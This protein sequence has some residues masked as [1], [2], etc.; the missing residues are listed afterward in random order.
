MTQLLE[1]QSCRT[2]WF[3]MLAMSSFVGPVSSAR[4]DIAPL[5]DVSPADPLTW[6]NAT[7]GYIGNTSVGTLTVDGNSDLLSAVG[8][9]G[10]E[11]AATGVVNVTGT[12]STWT[13]G[14]DLSIG[15]Y[16][17]G[18][19]AI[20]NRGTVRNTFGYVARQPGSIGSVT[21]DGIVSSWT[22]TNDLSVG[23]YGAGTLSISNR[24]RVTCSTYGYVGYQSGS[25]GVVAIGGAAST[26]TTVRDLNI[27]YYGGGTLSITT[28]GSVSSGSSP[29]YIGRQ[30]DSTG[31]VTVADAGSVLRTTSDLDVG[32]SGAGTLAIANGGSVTSN[33]GYIGYNA[34]S[35]GVATI[36]G[37]GS[38]WIVGS[39]STAS[40][41][42]YLG[43]QG[44]GSLSITNGGNYGGGWCVIGREA[45]STGLLTVSG[46]GS[47]FDGT[48][49]AVADFGS[50]TLSITGGGSV[51]SYNS[52]IA[53]YPGSNG[54]VTVAGTG[55]TWANGNELSIAGTYGSG[56]NNCR[57]TLSITQGGSVSSSTT[58][59]ATFRDSNGAVT[60]DGPGSTWTS[61]DLY[62]GGRTNGMSD[63]E[64]GTATVSITGGG[65]I[66]SGVNLP[67]MPP[68]GA[69]YL[70]YYAGS[71]ANV[72]VDGPNSIWANTGH[73]GVGYRGN[74]TLAITNGGSVS[75]TGDTCVGTYASSSGTIDF[76]DN[77]GTLTTR[78]LCTSPADLKGNGTINTRGLVADLDLKFDA[79]HGL[80]QT[81]AFPQ[82]GQTAT[83]NLDLTGDPT[84]LG[85][86]GV[87]WRSSGSLTIQDGIKVTSAYGDVG[88]NAGTTGIAKLDGPGST[89]ENT[90]SLN[91]GYD[92]IGILSITGGACVTGNMVAIARESLVSL[93]VGRGSSLTY[94][95]IESGSAGT[96]R[97]LV[98]ADVPA[99]SHTNRPT[100]IRTGT[101]QTIGCKMNIYDSYLTV[102]SAARGT[103]GSAIE[104]DLGSVQRALVA[105]DGPGGTNWTVGASF[106]SASITQDIT[107]TATPIDDAILGN[108]EL[109]AGVNQTILGGWTFETTNYDV[110]S[111]NPI[112]L[113]F[114]VDRDYP[115]NDL[116]VW[117]YDGHTWTTFFALDLTCDG[118]YASFTITGLGAYAVTVPEP[119]TLALGG[120]GLLALLACSWQ[121]RKCELIG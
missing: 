91:V 63:S 87:G 4:A 88:C 97:F 32:Y 58:C 78:T 103:P 90:G 94:R 30:T 75:V 104:L 38:R 107:F 14:T 117:H 28:G 73:L 24:G 93:D 33:N 48:L 62:L 8:Y 67:F 40:G 35:T 9:I 10:Y 12:G 13:N 25:T 29:C 79:N 15:Y 52:F 112:Y 1:A 82:S 74:A 2:F 27:G 109:A 50:G 18:A 118:A 72:T 44:G 36:D 95:S 98:A 70:A 120:F 65:R 115:L 6:N 111:Y 66:N 42:L 113:S 71:T 85:G 99:S 59:I 119:S 55:S 16:G 89:W 43:Y 20:A 64:G 105:D 81:L 108:L 49:L 102:A 114:Q 23:Y 22:N 34:G 19:L 53:S 41:S 77:G 5:G 11:D 110:S 17:D 61:G 116:K 100:N 39:G 96:M 57:G 121:R 56:T 86:L 80:T 92:G 47:T 76:G 26:W 45:G 54:L 68:S 21:V 69:S 3:A 46:T 106:R 60:V 7:T 101:I 51:S 83:V 84:T 37:T 31:A